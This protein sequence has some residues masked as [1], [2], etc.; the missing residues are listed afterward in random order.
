MQFAVTADAHVAS[1]A[2]RRS[3]RRV[4]QHPHPALESGAT[5]TVL[6]Y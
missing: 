5:S 3:P 6:R 1:V 4:G 2:L